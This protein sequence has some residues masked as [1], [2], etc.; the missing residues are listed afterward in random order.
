MKFMW[1]GYL[2]YSLGNCATTGNSWSTAA[3]WS[4]QVTPNAAGV[5]ALFN[6]PS[7]S[8]GATVDGSFTLGRLTFN[9]TGAFSH[10]VSASGA[11]VGL[12]LNNGS[13]ASVIKVLPSTVGN[14]GGNGTVGVPIAVAGNNALNLIAN[15]NPGSTTLTVTGP[16][17]G[18][19]ASLNINP[20]GENGTVTLL[21][22]N[23][24]GGA[25]SVTTLGGG[26]LV[27]VDGVGVPTDT[28]LAIG[29]GVWEITSTSTVVRSIGT[30]VGH[31]SVTGASGFAA[32]AGATARFRLGNGTGT[33]TWGDPAFNPTTLSFGTAFGTGAVVFENGLNLNGATRT[34]RSDGSIALSSKGATVSGAISNSTGV[35]GLAKEGTGLLMLTGPNTY[36]GPTTVRGGILRAN[37]GQ[38]LPTGSNLT[39]EAGAFESIR[40]RTLRPGRLSFR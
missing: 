18:S 25:G 4:P 37:D 16:I 9:S 13:S 17:T 19:G 23:T 8:A 21:A 15:T 7:G 3:N 22:A 30:G 40:P 35:A 39:L 33:V 34:I 28:A 38:G 11:G 29:G 26:R 27:A 5:V 10:T 20:A 36:N 1:L 2:V 6:G 31:L 24:Y 32:G 12:T 14:G